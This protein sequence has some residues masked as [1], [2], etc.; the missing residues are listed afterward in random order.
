MRIVAQRVT[1][2]SVSIE[3]RI[4]G[5]IEKGLVLLIG[6]RNGDTSDEMKFFSEKCLHLRIFEDADGKMNRS[7]LDVNGS[8]LAVSQFTLYA[9]TSKGRRPNFLD[10]ARP[11]IAEPLYNEFVAHL[12]LHNVHVETGIFGAMMEV[13]I[14]NSGPVTII[15]E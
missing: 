13:E 7:I 8:I 9:D 2:A 12:R 3:G 4:T 6:I 10:A 1:K 14:H 11:E 15:L 5:A